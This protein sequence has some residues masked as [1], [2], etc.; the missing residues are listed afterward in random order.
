MAVLYFS[1][2]FHCVY[3]ILVKLEM[4]LNNSGLFF[5]DFELDEK[6]IVPWMEGLT[7]LLIGF[8]MFEVVQI[9]SMLWVH[10]FNKPWKI[11]ILNISQWLA[12]CIIYNVICSWTWFEFF[13]EEITITDKYLPSMLHLSHFPQLKEQ[14]RFF[15]ISDSTSVIWD[16]LLSFYIQE[17]IQ[18]NNILSIVLRDSLHQPQYVEKLEKIL[19]FVIK[20]KA[21][22]LQDLDNIWAA[23][24]KSSTIC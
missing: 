19:R 12:Y 23:Q 14:V 1:P 18:Q 9:C 24:V 15:Y 4:F 6:K 22:T 5:N 20:E 10:S 8:F 21:L 13:K 3:V 17:W 7:V 16:A 2:C 11:I